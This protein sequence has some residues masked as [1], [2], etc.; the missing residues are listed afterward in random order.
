MIEYC[1]S[2]ARE[3]PYI[4]DQQ[5]VYAVI[6]DRRGRVMSESSNS[7][8]KTHPYQKSCGARVGLKEKEYLHAECS[9]IIK[10]RGKGTILYVARVDSKGNPLLAK[11]CPVCEVAISEHGKLKKIY[12]TGD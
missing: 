8:V 2:K 10:S 9:A 1:I 4:K 3:I 6:T 7:F 11:P 12:W 5:R